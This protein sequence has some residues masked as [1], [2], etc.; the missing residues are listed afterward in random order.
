VPHPIGLAYG[1]AALMLAVSFYCLGRL[2]LARRLGRRLDVAVNAAHVLMGLA[3]A[4]MLVPRWRLL[5]VGLWEAVFWFM[6]VWF[7][8][9]SLR[10]VARHGISGTGGDHRYHVT[11]HLVHMVMALAMLYMYAVGGAVAGSRMSM[12]A[13]SSITTGTASGPTGGNPTVA[14]ALIVVL[15][16]SA[17]WQLDSVGHFAQHP[18]VLGGRPEVASRGRSARAEPDP[19]RRVGTGTVVTAA[20]DERPWLAPRLEIGCH[21]ATCVT[22]A[23]MLILMV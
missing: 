19:V 7:L 13:G 16:V 3:M 11:H 4:G 14:L 9:S 23:Y 20:G 17:V 22:M 5:P 18:V 8:G 10:F 15:L 6:V 12:V 21:V 2:L 1:F